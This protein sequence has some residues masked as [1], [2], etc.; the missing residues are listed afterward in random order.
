MGIVL[1]PSAG[2]LAAA[3]CSHG[4]CHVGAQR[5][6]SNMKTHQSATN[7]RVAAVV[8]L[9]TRGPDVR[10]SVGSAFRCEGSPPESQFDS[11]SRACRR[12]DAGGNSRHRSIEF[13]TSAFT[14]PALTAIPGKSRL[15]SWPSAASGP[16][17]VTKPTGCRSNAI[18][19]P[20][21]PCR[22]FIDP[23]T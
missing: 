11:Y 17:T 22:K 23:I 5:F 4:T 16:K 6:L 3:F 20:A 2:G 10:R 14:V 18:S 12:D 21:D 8:V 7:L 19:Q 9:G 1:V 13:N 15:K